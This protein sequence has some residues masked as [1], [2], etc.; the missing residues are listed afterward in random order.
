MLDVLQDA[1]LQKRM[2]TQ[3]LAYSDQHSWKRRKA[4]Y[5]KIVDDL[6]ASRS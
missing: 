3:A 4:D 5:L 6:A 1:A 2:I